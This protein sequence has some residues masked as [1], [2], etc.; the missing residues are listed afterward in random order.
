[1]VSSVWRCAQTGWTQ[2]GEDWDWDWD[3]D[4]AW[5]CKVVEA[6]PVDVG[7]GA[8]YVTFVGAVLLECECR[9]ACADCTASTE[10]GAI[11]TK[12]VTATRR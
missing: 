8:R 5:G 12:M 1:M 6:S 4:W 7:D 11:I 2:R 10:A 9:T 3:W